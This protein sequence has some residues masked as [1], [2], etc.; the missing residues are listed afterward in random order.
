MA[1]FI[2]AYLGTTPLFSNEVPKTYR[3]SDSYT[4]PTEW[5]PLPSAS[6]N[7]IS[8]LHAVFDNTENFCTVR[9]NTTDA[10]SY[11]I[12]WGDGQ[13]ETATSNTIRTHVYNYSNAA[14]DS[15][16]VAKFGY[17]Q[18]LVRIYTQT[19]KTFSKMD[20]GIK[21]TS[22]TGLQI[23]SSGWLDMN[24]NLP[25][26]AA[27]VNFVLG[28]TAIRH[29][30]LERIH[31]TSWGA[32]TSLSGAF[33]NCTRLSSLNEHEWVTSSITNLN[34]AFFSCWSL[35]TLDLSN[36]VT[37]NV[38]NFGD[39][40]RDAL[41]IT[42]IKLPN[43]FVTQT[44]TVMANMFFGAN[45]LQ[46]IDCSNWDTR[47]V[48]S[49]AYVFNSCSSLPRVDVSNWNTSKVTAMNNMFQNCNV[50]QSLNLTNWNLNLCTNATTAFNSML[51]LRELLGCNISA[52]TSLG[53]PFLAN[54]NALSKMTLTGMN[55]TFYMTNCNLSASALNTIYSNLSANGAGKSVGV[56]GN[57][58]IAG[59]DPSIATAK[60][61]TVVTV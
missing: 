38:G 22:P 57:Y 52:A 45:S 40:F 51:N 1:E 30:F 42:Y 18:C 14:L 49:F 32:I 11:F 23:Y 47:N 8:A 44:A 29:G 53:T 9:M 3:S 2:K 13:I 28:T 4:R 21:V 20:L 60:G 26:L 43:Q 55:A 35:T 25:N 33:R 56:A 17:K 31:I 6:A 59:H 7:E 58:G 39:M 24:I 48:T 27:G 19:G 41:A 15:G 34:G 36:W 46:E 10:S 50:L 5:L 61:W 16:T 12:D 37:A 54:C